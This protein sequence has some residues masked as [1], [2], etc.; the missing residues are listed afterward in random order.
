M[1]DTERE[2]GDRGRPGPSFRRTAA[3][4][5]AFAASLAGLVAVRASP[6]LVGLA[7]LVGMVLVV[8]A[9]R[10]RRNLGRAG[11]FRPRRLSRRRVRLRGVD[12]LA[13]VLGVTAD[14]LRAHEPRYRATSIAKRSGGRRLLHVPDPATKR[15]Q[16]RILDRL[17]ARLPSHPAAHGFERGRS[18]ATNAAV[19]AGRAVVIHL[20][21]EGFFPATRAERIGRMFRRLAWDDEA[22][23]L[24]VRLTTH[25]GAL[26]QGA[27][28][29]PRLSNLVNTALD[30]DL[31]RAVARWHGRYTR[32]ADDVTISF[33][34]DWVG[35]VE[36]ARL[37][38]K[39]AFGAR[40]YRLHVR[41]KAS[42]RRRHQRQ[43]VCGL[44]VNEHVALPRETRRR[45]RAI[46]HHLAH[47]LP[48]T[49]SAA[50]LRGWDA[51]AS[52][53]RTQGAARPAPFRRARKP[54]ASWR[55]RRP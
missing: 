2:P 7:A 20:D 48:A 12:D 42:V 13:R 44:V 41:K 9:T 34:E 28:T 49:L 29:S 21:V 22:S 8:R 47:G 31:S 53:V 25:E 4:L 39:E 36:R 32:Y 51:Y 30:F 45:L 27:P 15:L 50:Q 24:L 33:P 18:I 55:R 54:M 35:A 52:M 26:P 46:R 3:A 40:G 23:D 14:E 37:A 16:R 1:S 10:P 11:E 17:L 5:V 6:T 43:I 38:A 19:H